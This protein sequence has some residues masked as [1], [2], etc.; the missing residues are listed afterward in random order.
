MPQIRY[1]FTAT[2]ANGI[3]QAF[4]S[5][6]AAA[7]KSARAIKNNNTALSRT[8]SS[9]S[10]GGGGRGRRGGASSQAAA[11][12]KAWDKRIKAEEKGAR[13]LARAQK[14]SREK[15]KR[16]A[17]KSIQDIKKQA[18][19]EAAAIRSANEKV[20]A[21]RRRAMRRMARSAVRGVARGVRRGASLALGAGG[22]LLAGA[23]R[24]QVSLENQATRLSIKGQ[25]GMGVD[26]PRRITG[27]QLMQHAR[28]VATTRP[29]AT[30]SGVLEG[31]G[32]FVQ[33]VGRV[34][35]AKDFSELM[36]TISTASGAD[37]KDVGSAMADMFQKFDVK[38]VDEM[39]TVM[40]KLVVQGKKGAFEMQDLAKQLP[41]VAAAGKVFGLKGAEGAVKL[42]GLLQVARRGQGGGAATATGMVQLMREIVQK[43]GRVKQLTGS[44][45]TG[46]LGEDILRIAKA[47]GADP[48][49]AAEGLKKFKFGRQATNALNPFIAEL[50]N[51]KDA[52]K[53][54]AEALDILRDKIKEATE[55]KDAETEVMDDSARAGKTMAAQMTAAWNAVS[56]QI[57]QALGPAL[58][59]FFVFLTKM[60]K[61]SDLFEKLGQAGAFLLEAIKSIVKL[62][63]KAGLITLKGDIDELSPEAKRVAKG[64]LKRKKSDLEDVR[65]QIKTEKDSE[66]LSNL[67]KREKRL[68]T[69]VA[70]LEIGVAGR[71]K[72][73]KE[74]FSQE[75]AEIFAQNEVEQSGLDP[76]SQEARDLRA[77]SKHIGYGR[78]Q[79]AFDRVKSGVDQEGG[80]FDV[81]TDEKDRVLGESGLGV[82]RAGGGMERAQ[83]LD[84]KALLADLMKQR[85]TTGQMGSDADIANLANQMGS[86][87]IEKLES[88]VT[89]AGLASDALSKIK[90]PSSVAPGV[91]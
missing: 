90:P 32:S 42:G 28:D 51:A 61:Q 46:D 4:N 25:T 50:K 84:M 33:K 58:K 5:I 8:S 2:G 82:G 55:A 78:A 73:T 17:W 59:D 67:R 70:S 57:N 22:A 3:V 63:A 49:G 30:A 29:G 89:N 19:K 47:A 83:M 14:R 12:K 15:W 65:T 77:F 1:S 20:I 11:E 10:G 75:A 86:L 41:K 13:E 74:R 43:S 6:E 54:T 21:A 35:I 52:G 66:K 9:S 72:L 56:G 37:M 64:S 38:S 81:F 79:K 53:T 40:S 85:D 18:D 23:A 69:D 71:D 62:A 48:E 34:D 44:K 76:E 36:A 31:M 27:T 68:V 7:N 39:A 60:S 45:S 91:P 88:L 87:N 26:D 24:D 80:F 16:N